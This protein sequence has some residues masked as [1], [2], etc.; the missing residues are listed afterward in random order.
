MPM[1]LSRFGAMEYDWH[2]QRSRSISSLILHQS[3]L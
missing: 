2:M 3:C 1:D